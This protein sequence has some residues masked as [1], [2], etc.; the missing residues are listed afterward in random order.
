[1][2]IDLSGKKTVRDHFDQLLNQADSF[3][4]SFNQKRFQFHLHRYWGIQ[5]S[6]VAKIINLLFS[7]T[8][9]QKISEILGRWLI[10]RKQVIRRNMR[11]WMR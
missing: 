8:L 10:W 4:K 11:L 2:S 6:V 9:Y 7:K 1:M 3:C 5:Y